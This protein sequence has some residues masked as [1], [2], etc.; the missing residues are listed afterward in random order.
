MNKNLCPLI[1]NNHS[2]LVCRR[3]EKTEEM[4]KLG[5]SNK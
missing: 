1:T 3:K 2:N 5:L 4:K